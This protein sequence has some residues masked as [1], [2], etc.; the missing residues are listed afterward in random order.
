MARR[1][2]G[3]GC[4]L[5]AGF[6][7]VPLG[8]A[9]G[10]GGALQTAQYTEGVAEAND[11]MLS[12]ALP[13]E[14]ARVSR[15]QQ[16]EIQQS[17]QQTSHSLS[18]D[19]DAGTLPMGKLRVSVRAWVNEKPIFDEEV[20]TACNPYLAELERLP[21]PQRTDKMTEVFK[22]ELDQ[23]IDREVIMQ[24]VYRKLEKNPK[25]LEKLTAS[26]RK[27]FEKQIA[28]MKKRANL[29]TDQEVKDMLAKQGTT[30]EG[31]RRQFERNYISMEYMKSRIF[32][33]TQNIGHQEIKEYYDQ[34]L[35]EFQI[36]DS[37]KWQDVFIAIG[38]KHRTLADARAFAEELA[39]RL[40]KGEDFK[41]LVDFDDGDSRY[42]SGDG[43]GQRR[44]EIKPSELE[45][46]LFRMRDGDVGPVVELSTGVHVFRLVKRE[47]AGQ[48][49]FSDTVQTTIHNKLRSEVAN[50]EYKR[51]LNELKS[52]AIIEI[53]R[54]VAR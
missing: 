30:L 31:M 26:A 42:R 13:P 33:I 14:S 6:L 37:V 27:D 41:K 19:K 16:P 20:R 10:H 32:P 46:Y 50:R 7:V 44:G 45:P 4:V 9:S 1:F 23:I 49:P 54:D 51:V 21:E 3:F 2:G 48:L 15:A 12:P 40:R 24:D 11:P 18:R 38:P 22:R 34:H 53:V 43:Y 28:S 5:L 39:G 17:V 25:V 47:Y 36:V 29:K 35:N 8:C 52:K